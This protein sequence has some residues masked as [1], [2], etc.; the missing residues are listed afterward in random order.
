[1]TQNAHWLEAAGEQ[2]SKRACWVW[3]GMRHGGGATPQ[4]FPTKKKNTVRA[5]DRTSSTGRH[6]LYRLDMYEQLDA[7]VSF[8]KNDGACK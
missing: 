3:I 6:P 2:I 4:R 8:L 1:M 5:K 7:G